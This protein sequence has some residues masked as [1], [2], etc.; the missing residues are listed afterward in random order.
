VI[1]SLNG[2]TLDHAIFHETVFHDEDVLAIFPPVA[3]G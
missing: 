1:F 2:L 3:G